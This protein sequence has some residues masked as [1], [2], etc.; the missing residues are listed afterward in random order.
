VVPFRPALLYLFL[1]LFAGI[2]G[3]DLV[4]AAIRDKVVIAKGIT[5]NRDGGLACRLTNCIDGCPAIEFN[6]T[7][8]SF[9]QPSIGSHPHSASVQINQ[10]W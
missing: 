1:F 4:I 3:F 8:I 2:Y 7:S 9:S 5:A 10:L 6:V